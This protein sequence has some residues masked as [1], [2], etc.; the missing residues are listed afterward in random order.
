MGLRIRDPAFYSTDSASDQDSDSDE[1][2]EK[3]D[4]EAPS[5][6]VDEQQYITLQL[7]D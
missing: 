7:F 3:I 1:M 6:D 2:A 5:G 4:A